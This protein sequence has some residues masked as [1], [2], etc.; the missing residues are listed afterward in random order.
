MH[1]LWSIINARERPSLT[2]CMLEKTLMRLGEGCTAVSFTF[3]L[4]GCKYAAYLLCPLSYIHAGS[5]HV[6][7]STGS[8]LAHREDRGKK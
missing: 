3:A 7:S 8:L 6:C 2:L 4:R 1:I 5:V